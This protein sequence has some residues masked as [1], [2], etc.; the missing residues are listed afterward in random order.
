MSSH[1]SDASASPTPPAPL[2]AVSVKF[3]SVVLV[4]G[5]C[6]KRDNGPTRLTT[7]DVR[8]DLKHRLA[9]G[10]RQGPHKFRTV[11]CS[12]IG[13]C[14]KKALAVVALVAGAPVLAAELKS[15]ADVAEFSAQALRLP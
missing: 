2:S 3:D 10:Q 5:E 9:Q 14:P 12:C 13:L 15:D 11:Q 1:H 6:E 4:C 7:K 8:K